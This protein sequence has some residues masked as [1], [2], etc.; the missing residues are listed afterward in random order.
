M[1]SRRSRNERASASTAITSEAA[2]MSNPVS[3]GMPSCLVPRPLTMLRSER[4][5]T[6]RTRFHV[7]LKG[8]IPSALS[9]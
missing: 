6:S 9:L 1:R 2:V 3:R 4:S 8:S 5:F 7:M